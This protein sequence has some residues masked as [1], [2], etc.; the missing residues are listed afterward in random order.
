MIPEARP[1]SVRQKIEI[2][3]KQGPKQ[4]DI[5]DVVSPY[6]YVAFPLRPE[7]GKPAGKV[8][9]GVE[10]TL[11]LRYPVDRAEDVSAALWAWE[12][13]GGIGARTRRGF[14]ALACM[15]IDGILF[16]PP[17]VTDVSVKITE[18]LANYAVK[19]VW[20]LGVP[21]LVRSIK[22]APNGGRSSADLAWRYLF[23]GLKKFRQS[24]H[25]DS[26]QRPYGRSKWPEPDAIRN[27]TGDSA[28][29]HRQRRLPFDKF[30]RAEFGLPIIFQFKD[31]NIGDPSQTSLEGANHDRLAS[32]LILRPLACAGERYVG[33]AAILHAPTQPPGG[34]RLKGAPGDPAVSAKLTPSE[35][36]QIE[37]LDG[38]TDVLQAF[39][40]WL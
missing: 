8:R 37:P 40:D 35:A 23:D 33:L 22:I 32:P 24:R 29:K 4:I 5:G 6:S 17:T 15:E 36:R 3:T 16:V 20:P 1:G 2:S 30:P 39:L 14:G 11:T 27:L 31:A 13:F 10:F 12:T 7:P 25:P 9:D 28:A 26:N 34:L 21:H 19:G 18:Y 38:N